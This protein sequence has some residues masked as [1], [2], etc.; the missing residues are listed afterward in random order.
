MIRVCVGV[1]TQQSVR[2]V[3]TLLCRPLVAKGK[4]LVVNNLAYSATEETL[5]DTFEKA[6]S[7][8]IP[9]NNGRPKG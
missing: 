2:P 6:V 5:Q 8:R 3:T 7:I 9:Q 4:T 1:V